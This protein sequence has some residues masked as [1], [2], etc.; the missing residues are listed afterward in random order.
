[1][2]EGRQTDEWARAMAIIA[3]IGNMFAA[4]KA[5]QIKVRDFLP[6]HI[7]ALAKKKPPTP[8]PEEAH[9]QWSAVRAAFK[10]ERMHH[11]G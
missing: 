8:S 2:V 1:M 5:D 3:T 6:Q 11:K 7:S 9:A 10:S 4:S